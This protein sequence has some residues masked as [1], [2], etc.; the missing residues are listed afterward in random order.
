MGS[1]SILPAIILM[2]NIVFTYTLDDINCSIERADGP[3][4]L[5][6]LNCAVKA[7]DNDNDLS[8]NKSI[9]P[10]DNVKNQTKII[11]RAC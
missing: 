5:K 8:N 7:L 2:I 1:I 3:K 11:K 9:V 4:L 10:I 6:A